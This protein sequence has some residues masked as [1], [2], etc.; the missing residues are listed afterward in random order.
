MSE[1]ISAPVTCEHLLSTK[2]LP[3]F[4]ELAPKAENQNS[5]LN[6]MRRSCIDP[7][8]EAEFGHSDNRPPNEKLRVAAFVTRAVIIMDSVYDQSRSSFSETESGGKIALFRKLLKIKFSRANE[9]Y[10]VADMMCTTVKLVTSKELYGSISD[11]AF[12]LHSLATFVYRSLVFVS[13]LDKNPENVT[14]S[15]AVR[16]RDGTNAEYARI[17]FD[18]A[19]VGHRKH[20]NYY[21]ARRRV[22]AGCQALQ[23]LDDVID[24]P[25]DLEEDT[26]TLVRALAREHNELDKLYGSSTDLKRLRVNN[27]IDVSVNMEYLRKVHELA[28]KTYDALAAAQREKF[29]IAGLDE[30][31]KGILLPVFK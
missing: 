1:Q 3:L 9:E 5:A 6:A 24:I 20:P 18:L 27:Q 14:Y 19:N 4:L 13:T 26:V 15:N 21:K 8:V 17:I 16:L 29:R 30:T 22:T 11:S 31:V 25:G 7:V 12:L 28:P 10:S 23:Y 2:E